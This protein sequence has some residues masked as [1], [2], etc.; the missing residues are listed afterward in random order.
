MIYRQ[1]IFL[2][3]NQEFTPKKINGLRNSDA[4]AAAY[5]PGIIGF[6]IM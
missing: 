2:P 4:W 6:M 3:A 1:D 5:I